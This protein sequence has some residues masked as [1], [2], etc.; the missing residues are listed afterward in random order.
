MIIHLIWLLAVFI[1]TISLDFISFWKE[2][3][4]P[5]VSLWSESLLWRINS[6]PKANPHISEYKLVPDIQV[7]IRS[8]AKLT[9]FNSLGL[10]KI[11]IHPWF[12]LTTVYVCDAHSILRFHRFY[13]VIKLQANS[14]HT[15]VMQLGHYLIQSRHFHISFIYL[16]IHTGT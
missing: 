9:H 1:F 13:I 6:L 7:W 8:R 16:D 4:P 15:F 10:E 5:L 14:I 3:S 12:K 2:I 11:R